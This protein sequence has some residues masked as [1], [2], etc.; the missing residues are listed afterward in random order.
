MAG[1][2]GHNLRGRGSEGRSK[3]VRAALGN[4]VAAGIACVAAASG[5]SLGLPP[6]SYFS[7]NLHPPH[8]WQSVGGGKQAPAGGGAACWACRW[9]ADGLRT[10]QC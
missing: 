9:L 1:R 10:S 3:P 2:T 4:Q 5:L 7:L 6:V 8:R